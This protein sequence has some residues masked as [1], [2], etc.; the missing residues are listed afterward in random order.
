MATTANTA[1]RETAIQG[2]VE[3]GPSDYG[4]PAPRVVVRFPDGLPYRQCRA[5]MF[6]LAAEVEERSTEAGWIVRVQDVFLAGGGRKQSYLE[7]EL[8]SGSMDEAEAALEV[9]RQAVKEVR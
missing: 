2:T 4:T 8:F 7:L 3:L 5:W 6:G 1:E 9:L